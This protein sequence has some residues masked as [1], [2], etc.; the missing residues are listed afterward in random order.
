[1]SFDDLNCARELDLPM[2]EKCVLLTL[3]NISKKVSHRATVSI[4][5]LVQWSSCSH[6]TVLRALKALEKKQLIIRHR[7]ARR[8]ATTY[9]LRLPDYPTARHA[10]QIRQ[11]GWAPSEPTRNGKV[12]SLRTNGGAVVNQRLDRRDTS[13]G[14]P[15]TSLRSSPVTITGSSPAGPRPAKEGLDSLVEKL[16]TEIEKPS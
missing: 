4:S 1:V 9:E 10:R 16:H 7:S 11:S 3:A 12:G 8:R 15:R 2:P 5:T 13:D 6:T 14:P